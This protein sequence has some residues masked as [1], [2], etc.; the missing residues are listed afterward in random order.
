MV[1]RYEALFAGSPVIEMLAQFLS[2]GWRQSFGLRQP[3]AC[4]ACD[5]GRRPILPSASV[6]IM[7]RGKEPSRDP[8]WTL[9][10]VN[11][12]SNREQIAADAASNDDD[13]G[14]IDKQR[15]VEK[16]I[17][18]TYPSPRERGVGVLW[19]LPP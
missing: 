12:R 18:L 10:G 2:D 15:Y 13:E 14:S 1:P 5:V 9:A 16:N 19:E 8:P 11:S 3:F 17:S 6:K 7:R 4:P